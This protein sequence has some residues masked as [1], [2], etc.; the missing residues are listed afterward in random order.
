MSKDLMCLAILRASAFLYGVVIIYQI[1]AGSE[2]F[3][4]NLL[5]PAVAALVLWRPRTEGW[6][7]LQAA[8]F[9]HF[10]YYCFGFIMALEWQGANLI[11]F[12]RD[13]LVWVGPAAGFLVAGLFVS[14]NR[15]L[16]GDQSNTQPSSR[17][18]NALAILLAASLPFLPRVEQIAWNA[19]DS[20]VLDNQA[21]VM[22][23]CF[24]SDGKKIGVISA[25][26]TINIW[27]VEAKTFISL[28][29]SRHEIDSLAFSSDG[30]YA[31]VGFAEQSSLKRELESRDAV[32]IDL[33][34]LT[35]GKRIELR[36]TK[37][38]RQPEDS[39]T[40]VSKVAFSPDSTYLACASGHNK[41]FIEIWEV[42]T[43]KLINSFDTNSSGINF[44]A[45]V[46]SPDGRY[47][48]SEYANGEIVLW[49]AQTAVPLRKLSE[50][51][52]GNIRG[53]AYSP[54]GRYLAVAFN[55]VWPG[56]SSSKGFID[57]WETAAGKIYKTLEWDSDT[58]I[59]GLAYSYDGKYIA[60]FLQMEDMVNIWD[61]ARG[62]QI[63]TLTGP[64]YGEPI[65]SIAYG[66]DGRLAVASGQYIKLYNVR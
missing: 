15:H 60:S 1:I 53:I 42:G 28:R 36:R 38:V 10:L 12:G 56:P 16:F 11:H 20:R 4:S 22:G 6:Y 27:D 9:L 3:W 5:L 17:I 37:P 40:Q 26:A 45:L 13:V 41:V 61:V 21:Q 58:Q 51:Y 32:K 23:L 47:V 33:W 46:Y 49:D 35:T 63:K 54:D 66:P 19:F 25:G 2:H 34:E 39:H 65:A 30:K 59:M 24:S 31:A 14:Q 7:F 62:R 55:K 52:R 57:I 64:V 29:A 8:F 50:G 44:K 43:R 48:A 18:K